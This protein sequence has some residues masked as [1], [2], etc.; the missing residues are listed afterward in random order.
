MKLKI[1]K[2][3]YDQDGKRKLAP[4]DIVENLSDFERGRH[5]AEGNAVP[6]TGRKIE[7]AISEPEEQR[8][9]KRG[10]KKRYEPD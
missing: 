6:F 5:L 9:K 1:V 8:P 7:R 10:R 2:P 3:C 4:G